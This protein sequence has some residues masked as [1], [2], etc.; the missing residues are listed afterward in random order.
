MGNTARVGY[1]ITFIGET[2][3]SMNILCDKKYAGD[4]RQVPAYF[5]NP[6]FSH[7]THVL[8]V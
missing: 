1:M 2:K 8:H 3:F 4:L 5:E 7:I 6:D